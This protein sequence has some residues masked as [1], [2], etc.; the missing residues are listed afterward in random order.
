MS[1]IR[2]ED[3]EKNETVE[4]EELLDYD[5]NKFHNR[6]IDDNILNLKVAV[7]DLNNASELLLSMGFNKHG[8]NVLLMAKQL[9]EEHEEIVEKFE[10][11]KK[12]EVKVPLDYEKILHEIKMA[13][14]T[15]NEKDRNIYISTP[16]LL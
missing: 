7:I 8:Y 16:E 11:N 13:D 1:T 5:L 4:T 10:S 15:D 9:A 14:F 2:N 3:F 6:S 12:P